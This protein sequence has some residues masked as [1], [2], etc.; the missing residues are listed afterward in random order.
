MTFKS[1]QML[2][3]FRAYE[4]LSQAID[5]L[6]TVTQMHEDSRERRV[7][8]RAYLHANRALTVLERY[9]SSKQVRDVMRIRE[10]SNK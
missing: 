1:P 4:L 5:A 8:N 6:G 7:A 10:H 2:E 3:L 9:A